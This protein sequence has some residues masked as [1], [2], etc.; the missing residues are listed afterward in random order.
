MRCRVELLRRK[1]RARDPAGFGAA[2]RGPS[3]RLPCHERRHLLRETQLSRV[4]RETVKRMF[5]ATA[6]ALDKHPPIK[7][8]RLSNER[9]YCG[10]NLT[11][12]HP[13]DCSPITFSEK[14]SHGRSHTGGVN[15]D[16]CAHCCGDGDRHANLFGI[17]SNE[18]AC[19]LG[20]PCNRMLQSRC[21]MADLLGKR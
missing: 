2:H 15:R 12:H 18:I 6:Q 13:A 7:E 20:K 1:S 17:V 5:A 4:C 10:T 19:R 11:A 3:R 8:G 21:R 9:P 14:R 16:C